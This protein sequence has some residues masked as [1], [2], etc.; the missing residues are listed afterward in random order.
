MFHPLPLLQMLGES[1]ALFERQIQ[2]RASG[3]RRLGELVSSTSA[4][5]DEIFSKKRKK[6]VRTS[7]YL[8]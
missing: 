4:G 2:T 7:I 5:K 3:G 8:L 1:R 6:S